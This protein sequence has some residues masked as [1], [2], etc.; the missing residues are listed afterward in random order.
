MHGTAL[1]SEQAKDLFSKLG[2]GTG[3]T[4][5]GMD[6]SGLLLGRSRGWRETEIKRE[7]ERAADGWDTANDISA[8]NGAAVPG[9]CSCVGGF[10]EDSVGTTVVA[11]DGD[12]FVQEAVKV[13]D[14]D[15]F[16]ITAS[17]DVK[18][19]V[20]NAADVLEQTFEGAAIVDDD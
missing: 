20:Q 16:V 19:D 2:G 9:V 13:F 3:E 15:S 14:A 12:S 6:V 5:E 18:I 7:P 10:D 8:I 4:E 17:S 1:F 11:S